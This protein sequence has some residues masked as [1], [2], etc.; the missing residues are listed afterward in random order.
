MKEWIVIHPDAAADWNG[1]ATEALA[2][3]GKAPSSAVHR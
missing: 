3:V 1:L 2:F